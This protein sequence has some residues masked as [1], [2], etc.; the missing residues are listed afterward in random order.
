[1]YDDLYLVMFN[2]I[3]TNFPIILYGLV[4]QNIS[5][6]VRSKMTMNDIFLV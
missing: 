2:G 4:E 6:A 1:M 3:Y 5:E